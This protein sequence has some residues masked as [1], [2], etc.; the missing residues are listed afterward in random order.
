[1]RR[2]VRAMGV[3]LLLA[4]AFGLTLAQTLPAELRERIGVLPSAQR[5]MLYR[6]AARLQ[7]MAPTQRQAFEQR[8]AQWKALPEAERRV[9]RER[10]QA[11][12]AL[13]ADQRAQLQ[14]A[15]A[16]YTALPVERQLDLK[17]RYAQLD[18]SQHH[19]WLLGPALG[20]DWARL[21]PLLMQVAPRQRQPLLVAL[22]AMTP[23]QRVDLGV[24][25]Q[26]TP[27]QDRNRLRE[28]LLAVPAANRGAWLL[29][30]LDR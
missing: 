26:R 24:L 15:A 9:R 12:Q 30:Q 6:R 16:D 13:P 29:A 28:T 11:W 17:Q 25:A 7:A 8:L 27:P 22:R 10:F 3:G 18:D 14:D 21:Q 2:E 5:D 1:M 4:C 20:A 23:Q 19:G